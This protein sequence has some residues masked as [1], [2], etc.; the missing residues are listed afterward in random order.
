LKGFVYTCVSWL[1]YAVQSRP[2]SG[3]LAGIA[4]TVAPTP[5]IVVAA[6]YRCAES[7]DCR[8]S[9]INPTRPRAVPLPRRR[10]LYSLWTRGRSAYVLFVVEVQRRWLHLVGITP[11]SRRHG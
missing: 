11:T 6:A 9:V 4:V 1:L 8:F 2:A 10:L 5:L 3:A 7:A